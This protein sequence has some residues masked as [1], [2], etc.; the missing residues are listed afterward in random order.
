[1]EFFIDLDLLVCLAEE[2]DMVTTT[3]VIVSLLAGLY[4]GAWGFG[5]YK[6]RKSAK[7]EQ[8]NKK[9]IQAK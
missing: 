4:F 1:M 9:N 5:Y 6:G 2:P 8:E 7:R 3:I